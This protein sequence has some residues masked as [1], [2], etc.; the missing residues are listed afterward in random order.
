MQRPASNQAWCNRWDE[1]SEE[2]VQ[3]LSRPRCD[4]SRVSELVRERRRLTTAQPRNQKGDPVV[5][6]EEQR[7][8]L[9]RSLEREN[10]LA[11]L[12]MQ[13]RDSLGLAMISLKAGKAVRGRF[14]A[15]ERRPR[16]F[17][18]QM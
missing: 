3:E 12:A 10:R 14:G 11:E 6:I 1:L 4:T 16:V 5:T 13:V 17:S 2:L 9:E 15:L 7:A 18:A 8:W